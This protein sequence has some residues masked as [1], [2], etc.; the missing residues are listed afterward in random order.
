MTSEIKAV[1]FSRLYSDST[2]GRLYINPQVSRIKST[3]DSKTEKKTWS[4][5][6][7]VL[8]VIVTGFV[9]P[10]VGKT[11]RKHIK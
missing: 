2:T 11:L 4:D 9:D 1:L 8:K 3:A 7:Q 10:V 6:K 5:V